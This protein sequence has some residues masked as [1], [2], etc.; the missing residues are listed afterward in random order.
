MPLKNNIIIFITKIL[1][2]QFRILRFSIDYKN[3]VNKI[4]II[5]NNILIVKKKLLLQIKYL[6]KN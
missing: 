3:D 4:I 2:N 1:I 6:I 5:N